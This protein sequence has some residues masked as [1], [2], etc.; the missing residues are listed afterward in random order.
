MNI[1]KNQSGFTHLTF[2]LVVLAIGTIAFVGKI[3]YNDGQDKAEVNQTAEIN[4]VDQIKVIAAEENE[5]TTEDIEKI[6]EPKNTTEKPPE[7]PEPIEKPKSSTTEQQK[8]EIKQLSITSTD[9][10]FSTDS[11]ILTAELPDTYQGKCKALI[12]HLDGSNAQWHET[13]FGPAN[14]CS[15]TVPKSKLTSADTWQFYMY[16]YNTADTIKGSSGSKSFTL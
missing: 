14:S 12:K 1:T 8:T 5:K 9:F 13:G 11:V 4:E 15:V 10:S 7:E 6:E 3:V 16:F 2:L